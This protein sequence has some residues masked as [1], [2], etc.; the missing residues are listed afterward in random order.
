MRASW[1]W[2]LA[3]LVAVWPTLVRADDPEPRDRPNW[4]RV[5]Q[6]YVIINGAL[7]IPWYWGNQ[8]YSQRTWEWRWDR[9]SW[10]AKLVTFDAVRFDGDDFRTN[11]VH[12]T[13]VSG[14]SYF[15]VGRSN[16]L[17]IPESFLASVLASTTWEYLLEFREGPS[18]NDMITTPLSGIALGE[19]V[20]QLGE[21]FLR[22]GDH[23]VNWALA[24]GFGGLQTFH[25]RLDKTK[26][27]RSAT[28]D[29]LGFAQDRWHRFEL[30]AAIQLADQPTRSETRMQLGL[31]TEIVTI[32]SFDKPARVS[33]WVGG[34]N[35]TRLTA[36]LSYHEQGIQEILL[37]AR[38]TIGGY[39][40][41]DLRGAV[42]AL[43]GHAFYA[44]FV[45]SF[46]YAVSDLD[47]LTER[48]GV[49]ALG[50][51]FDAFLE[52]AP[53]RLRAT[54]DVM[55]DFAMVTPVAGAAY[56]A[57]L[58]PNAR[59]RLSFQTNDYYYAI[60]ASVL[61]SLTVELAPF[62][63]AAAARLD[64]FSSI[65]GM[66]RRQWQVTDD[67]HFADRRL[68]YRVTLG[69]APVRLLR[70]WA[71]IERKVRAGTVGPFSADLRERLV[72]VGAS[73]VL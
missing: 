25:R 3:A 54:L 32:H 73:F 66:E 22:G 38:A 67:S 19:T 49:S 55:G 13:F 27:P 5:L 14:M 17:T 60:G 15:L 64:T 53:L 51:T 24:T 50:V 18:V 12:H 8:D 26:Q 2:P 6:E 20:F 35:F 41:Q 28:T 9:E 43:A 42:G 62:F 59:T 31:D 72:T 45:S 37:R 30:H 46:D 63:L 29:S 68:S 48:L 34:E 70:M 7:G 52:R 39:Y 10:K 65:E 4:P 69:V 57:W 40:D 36:R 44:G 21:L 1:R 61:P 11:A 56:R 23:P 47:T 16:R 58:G 33:R 71:G